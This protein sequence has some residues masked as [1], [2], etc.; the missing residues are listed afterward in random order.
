MYKADKEAFIFS[1]NYGQ[2]YR[3]I[4]DQK[5]IYCCSDVGPS[6]GGNTLGLYGN[7][8]NKEHAGYCFTKS[9]GIALKYG[10]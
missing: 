4:D 3:V 6:F 8:L 9:E 7:P 2:I 1:I 5:A 10:I